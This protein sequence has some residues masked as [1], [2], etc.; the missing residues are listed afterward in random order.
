MLSPL[1]PKLD[2]HRKDTLLKNIKCRAKYSENVGQGLS[3]M[4][5]DWI[6]EK[7][8]PIMASAIINNL[9]RMLANE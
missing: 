5:T 4:I 7:T 8:M 2:E 1:Q 6:L 3:D 9:R